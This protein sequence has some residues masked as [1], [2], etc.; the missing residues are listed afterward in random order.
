[1]CISFYYCKTKQGPSSDSQV[2]L[3]K[4]EIF[5]WRQVASIRPINV[6]WSVCRSVYLCV[7][8]FSKWKTIEKSK[9]SYLIFWFVWYFWSFYSSS[10]A[11]LLLFTR[12]YD[13]INQKVQSNNQKNQIFW[14]ILN[15][16]LIGKLFMEVHH[17]V[18]KS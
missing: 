15:I 8:I 12:Q 7:E 1:M 6:C 2:N 9:E 11:F 4:H 14:L 13:K 3:V 5:K 18:H 10:E 17:C 16:W